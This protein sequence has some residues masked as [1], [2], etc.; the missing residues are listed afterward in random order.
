MTDL[1]QAIVE[2]AKANGLT[3]TEDKANGGWRVMPGLFAL[4]NGES[5]DAIYDGNKLVGHVAKDYSDL[6][7]AA[8]D[9]FEAG[10]RIDGIYNRDTPPWR[11]LRRALA[12]A[13]G[14]NENGRR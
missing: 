6:V 14:A 10:D 7:A 3:A 4:P 9:L 1:Q 11:K 8:P 12:K 5:S 2:L 13:K